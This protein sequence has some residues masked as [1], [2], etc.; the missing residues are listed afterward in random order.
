MELK[1]FQWGD[2]AAP[3]LVAIHGVAGN[4]AMYDKVVRE[5]WGKHFRVISFDLR[6]HGESSWDPPWTNA[7]FVGDIIDTIDALGLQQPDWVGISFGGRLLLQVIAGHPDRVRRAA[8]LEPVIQAT[9]ELAFRRANQELTAGVWDSFDAFL[10]T[11]V[12]IWG[13]LDRAELIAEYGGHFQQLPDGRVQRRTCQ[14]AVVS[15]FSE[16]CT[17][18]ARPEQISR[19]TT[20]L[21]SPAFGLVTPEQ[22]K[23]FSPYVEKWVPVPGQHHVLASAYEE[24]ATAVEDFLL[25]G[26]PAAES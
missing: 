6:G 26:H 3:P 5:R 8:V 9:T 22:R 10:D 19:P 11:R 15:I 21:Y 24:T 14:P 23:A 25:V 2:P 1:T 20:I 13:E 7:A 17:L 12:S 16:S 4:H 18:A